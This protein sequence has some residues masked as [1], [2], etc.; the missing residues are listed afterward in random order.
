MWSFLKPEPHKP[1]LPKEKIDPTYKKLRL[2]VFL[3]IFIGYA[4]YY[5]VR[6]NFTLAMP[7]LQELGFDKGDLGVALSLMLL[8]TGYRSF[9]GEGF[10]TGVVPVSFCRWDWCYRTRDV[11]FGNKCRSLFNRGHVYYP[12]FDWLVPGDGLAT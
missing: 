10:P 2:Q 11:V 12:V 1:L 3:G 6:K 8:L 4:G 5:L 7:Y 9:C